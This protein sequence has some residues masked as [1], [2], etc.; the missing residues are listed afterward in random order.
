MYLKC[1]SDG[2]IIN[3]FFWGGGE[4]D[5]VRIFQGG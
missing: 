1:F 3:F 5:R 2:Y 4:S